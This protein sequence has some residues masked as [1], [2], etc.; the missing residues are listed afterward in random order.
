[1]QKEKYTKVKNTNIRLCEEAWG[2]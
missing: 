1:V 2:K